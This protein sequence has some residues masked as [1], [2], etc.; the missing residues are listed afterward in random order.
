MVP[1]T[2]DPIQIFGKVLLQHPPVVKGFG[3]LG[4]VIRNSILGKPRGD[5]LVDV[6]FG[7][8]FGMKTKRGV[9]VIICKHRGFGVVATRISY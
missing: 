3:R 6:I 1:S 8:A 4:G 7:I 9:G 2:G 5:G